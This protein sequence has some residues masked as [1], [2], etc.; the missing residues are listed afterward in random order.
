MTAAR[1]ARRKAIRLGRRSSVGDDPVRPIAPHPWL[2]EP[3]ANASTPFP[4][5]QL[6]SNALLPVAATQ[7]VPPVHHPSDACCSQIPI[8]P[9]ATAVAYYA[10]FRALALL[11]RLPS[12]RVDGGVMQASEKPAQKRPFVE[13][14]GSGSVEP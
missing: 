10:R 9:A 11:G 3:P 14:F 13:P 6:S 8:E 1:T 2:K 12:A 7:P 5:V 4:L